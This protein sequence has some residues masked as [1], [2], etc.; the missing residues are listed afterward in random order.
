MHMI[1]HGNNGRE[2]RPE[3]G[4]VLPYYDVCHE[5]PWAIGKTIVN[6]YY[7]SKTGPHAHNHYYRYASNCAAN[8]NAFMQAFG[9]NALPH[10]ELDSLVCTNLTSS[11]HRCCAC[12]D[13][14]LAVNEEFTALP[15][16]PRWVPNCGQHGGYPYRPCTGLSSKKRFR[17]CTMI[18]NAKECVQ[19]IPFEVRPSSASKVALH[20]YF[21]KSEDDFAMKL[22]KGGADMDNQ[23][24]RASILMDRR[25]KLE[26]CAFVC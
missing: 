13:D 25:H 6:T 3:S 11:C 12:S 4:G 23:Q 19:R 14:R 20:H 26:Q 24:G 16:R 5:E 18:P 21:V 8:A 22:A 1:L 10:H 7:L 9:G 2:H 17:K 15:P